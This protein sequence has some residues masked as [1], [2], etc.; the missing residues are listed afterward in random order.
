M[1]VPEVSHPASNAAEERHSGR[2]WLQLP[3]AARQRT[4]QFV[5]QAGFLPEQRNEQPTD[6]SQRLI[7]RV[8]G[9]STDVGSSDDASFDTSAVMTFGT[10]QHRSARVH[11]PPMES[12]SAVTVNAAQPLHLT[13]SRHS[14]SVI[15]DPAASTDR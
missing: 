7:E 14:R 11:F 6:E 4:H 5:A 1:P 12:G 3:A 2:L 13:P 15:A 9:T 8:P 10:C